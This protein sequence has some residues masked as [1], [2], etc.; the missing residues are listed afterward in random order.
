MADA[1][2]GLTHTPVIFNYALGS[3]FGLAYR[4]YITS[5]WG[6]PTKY[7]RQYR[8]EVSEQYRNYQI[9][10][11]DYHSKINQRTNELIAN[12][13]SPQ[14]AREMAEQQF[15]DSRPEAPAFELKR[16]E[17]S[18]FAM[19]AQRTGEAHAS[20]LNW[21]YSAFDP[22]ATNWGRVGAA[23]A[24]APLA[25]TQFLPI[26]PV[27]SWILS[28]GT[29]L[30]NREDKNPYYIDPGGLRSQMIKHA[31]P[32]VKRQYGG[33][34]I[35]TGAVRAHE[36]MW[37][38]QAGVQAVWGNANPG[39]SYVDFSGSMQYNPRAANYLRYESKYRPFFKHDEY[40]E[41][42]ANMGLVTRNVDPFEL[43]MSRNAE[44]RHYQFPENTLFRFLSPGTLAGYKG[45]A[46]LAQVGKGVTNV[47]NF[48]RETIDSSET[49][50]GSIVTGTTH[51]WN[52]GTQKASNYMYKKFRVGGA[53]AIRH[54]QRC[55]APTPEGLACRA[56]GQKMSC[57]D[58]GAIVRAGQHH[59]CLHGRSP[60]HYRDRYT[61]GDAQ[62]R[63]EDRRAEELR[64]RREYEKRMREGK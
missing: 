14:A 11:D 24:S 35:A 43:S 57:P 20:L 61:M 26:R 22:T 31:G 19:T 55:G 16:D 40:L 50:G 51:L 64:R 29:P 18:P 2:M 39:A 36:D 60:D 59:S 1:F 10:L 56:C 37:R 15:R 54:C 7:D 58:C 46:R 13:M 28:K 12:K 17:L 49:R 9:V 23:L 3:P 8:P 27:Q 5:R 33:T 25:L 38:Y 4:T 63:A 42:Q 34:E 41:R 48:F 21:A 52:A 62:R 44:L 30:M 32:M 6:A 53:K 45:A 47:R